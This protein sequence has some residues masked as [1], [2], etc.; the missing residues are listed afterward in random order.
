MS[1]YNA[2]S[3]PNSDE[4]SVLESTK[5]IID[6]TTNRNIRY[7]KMDMEFLMPVDSAAT[8]MHV[9]KAEVETAGRNLPCLTPDWTNSLVKYGSV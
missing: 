1:Y 6:M 2:G 8:F 4:I 9:C 5:V 3:D 7:T